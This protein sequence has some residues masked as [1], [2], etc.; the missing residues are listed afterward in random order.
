[1]NEKRLLPGFCDL[2]CAFGEPGS[3]QAETIK[4][5]LRAAARG[6]YSI[7]ALEPFTDP[8]IDN[9]AQVQLALARAQGAACRLLPLACAAREKGLSSANPAPRSCD[10]TAAIAL[11]AG[12][13]LT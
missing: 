5:G 10:R 11:S 12:A 4:S 6:G 13:K 7:A 3:E 9:D 1:M 8:P 2:G